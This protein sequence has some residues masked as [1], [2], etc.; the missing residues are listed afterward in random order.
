MLTNAPRHE[1]DAE[2]KRVELP[3]EVVISRFVFHDEIPAYLSL[4]DFAINPVKPVPTKKYCT[5]IKDGEYWA[6][7]LPVIISHDISDDSG[8]IENEN[9]GVIINFSE[10]TG[11]NRAVLKIEEFFKTQEVLKRKIMQIAA[12]YRSYGIAKAI[13]EK[14][15]GVP[16]KENDFR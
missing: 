15:Y 8:I 13:Y 9:I 1:I 12:K 11:M 4:G 2:C 7:G 14:I 10:K 16:R 3:N 6:M 5:S